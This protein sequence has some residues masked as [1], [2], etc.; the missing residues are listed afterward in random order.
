[1]CFSKLEES[2][3]N[4]KKLISNHSLFNFIETPQDLQHFLQY[5]SFEVWCHEQLKQT[6]EFQSGNT[7]AHFDDFINLLT[8]STI[9][10]EIFSD[11]LETE[12][13]NASAKDQFENLD[14]PAAVIAFVNFHQQIATK[15]QA[16]QQLALL[17]FG[18][19]DFIADLVDSLIEEV[20]LKPH[21]QKL[22]HLKVFFEQRRFDSRQL[23]QEKKH[24]KE[25][26]GQ[27]K[28]KWKEAQIAIE[29]LNSLREEL[30]DTIQKKIL[31][32]KGIT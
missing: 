16:H 28:A 5:F 11:F 19:T 20:Q 25:I 32:Q 7:N 9:Q 26:C 8:S 13:Q 12:K 2:S 10:T 18:Q 21:H 15:E 29:K 14:L 4:G 1:M 24:L 17:I 30:W 27:D 23:Q 22:D 3:Q 31:M 6:Q